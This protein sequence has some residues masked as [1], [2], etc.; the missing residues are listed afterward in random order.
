MILQIK[1]NTLTQQVQYSGWRDVTYSNLRDKATLAKQSA[2]K[3][4]TRL[5][6]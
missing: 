6:R 4:A 2:A 1:E 3:F 5:T